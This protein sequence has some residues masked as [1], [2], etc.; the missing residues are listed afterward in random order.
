ILQSLADCEKGVLLNEKADLMDRILNCFALMHYRSCEA[1]MNQP[2]QSTVAQ[3]DQTG[4]RL[5]TPAAPTTRFQR[6]MWVTMIVLCV[7]GGAVVIRRMV[8]RAFPPSNPP[9]QFAGLDEAFAEKRVLTM[10]H[11]VPALLLV[12]L[13]PFQFSRS[14]RN[15]HLRVHRWIGRTVMVLGLIIGI[16]AIPMVR[17]PVGGTIEVACILFFDAL[18]LFSLTKAYLH[19]R[20][21]QVAQHREWMIRAMSVALGVATVRP[22]MGAF[23]ATS[24]LTGLTPHDFFGIA[25]SIGFTL[26]WIV[27]ELWIRYTRRVLPTALRQPE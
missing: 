26:T 18:F 6:L 11:I 19:I 1:L 25:F 22:I 16:S 8:A 21:R 24:R 3:P 13:V 17:H 9:A 2:G 5:A 10:I 20:H 4:S 23:F 14:F 12:T 15:R 7:I 27:G